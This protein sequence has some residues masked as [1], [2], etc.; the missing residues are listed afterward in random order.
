MEQRTQEHLDRADVYRDFANI[1]RTTQGG[2]PAGRN[3]ASIIAFYAAV[4]YVNAYLWQVARFAPANHES[5]GAVL[6]RWPPLNAV[7]TSYEHLRD[8]GFRARYLPTYRVAPSLVD[9]L[10]DVD[11]RIV[12]RVVRSQISPQGN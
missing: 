8:A 6:D 1:I 9:R 3:W 2:T 12:E 5:R 10:L 7:T 4:H 11:L